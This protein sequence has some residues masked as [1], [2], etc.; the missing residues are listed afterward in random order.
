M[1]HKS[2]GELGQ[3]CVIGELSKYGL[4]IA[5]LLSDNY[6]FEFIVV[7]GEKLFRVQVKTSTINDNGKSVYFSLTSNNWLKHTITK[8][9]KKDCDVFACYDLIKHRTFLLKPEQFENRSSFTIR[10]EKTKNNNLSNINWYEDYELSNKSVKD[11]FGF[12]PVDFVSSFSTYHEKKY[13]VICK[14]CKKTFHAQYQKQKYCSP[15]C[16]IGSRRVVERPSKEELI[17]LIQQKPMVH[18]GK[19]FGVSDNA[20][21][22]WAISYDI[23][24]NEVKRNKVVKVSS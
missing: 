11:V 4:G 3:N 2:I 19:Q 17:A 21:K 1:N 6:P 24:I 9:T 16:R 8:Y 20:V 14:K 13:D 15:E 18:I 22:K 7:A 12:T 5:V 23:N 10:Y